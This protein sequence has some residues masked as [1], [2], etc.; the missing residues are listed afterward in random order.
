MVPREMMSICGNSA[1][2]I[3]FSKGGMC[4]GCHE[5]SCQVLI[6]IDAVKQIIEKNGG[7]VDRAVDAVGTILDCMVHVCLVPDIAGHRLPGGPGRWKER[8]A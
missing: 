4:R 3:D 8:T 7:E 2:P 5:D 6:I 1:I